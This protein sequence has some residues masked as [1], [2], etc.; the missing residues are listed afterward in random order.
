MRISHICIHY[1][2]CYNHNKKQ[3]GSLFFLTLLNKI[4]LYSYFVV[5]IAIKSVPPDNKVHVA[6][7]GPN[8]VL[9]APGGPNDGPMNLVIRVHTATGA[10]CIGR[11]KHTRLHYHIHF[12]QLCSGRD[13]PAIYSTDKPVKNCE[14]HASMGPI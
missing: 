11:S 12:R 14:T 6:I 7:M 3:S 4:I 1:R 5:Q 9:S 13:F 8:S 10:D 2:L